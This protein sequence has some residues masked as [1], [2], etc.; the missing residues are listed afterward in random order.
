MTT[1]SISTVVSFVLIVGASTAAAQSPTVPKT[2][3]TSSAAGAA[4]VG[5]S[6]PGGQVISAAQVTVTPIG[7]G[8]SLTASIAK[9]GA[10]AL[11]GLRPGRYHVALTSGGATKV[12]QNATFGE[13]VNAGLHAPGSAVSEGA[14]SETSRHETAKNAVGNIRAKVDPNSMPSRLSMNMTIGR[15]RHQLDVDGAPV[16]LDVG[17]DGRLSGMIVPR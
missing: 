9:N 3:P 13:K 11:S 6:L 5:G 4:L 10:F 17:A 16:E 1:S 12:T 2:T 15:Q 14:G 7:G 8:A